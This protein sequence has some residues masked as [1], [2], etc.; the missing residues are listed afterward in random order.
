MDLFETSRTMSPGENF[1]A[2]VIIDDY[3]IFRLM[4]D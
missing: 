1:Y 3:S 2:I 4:K